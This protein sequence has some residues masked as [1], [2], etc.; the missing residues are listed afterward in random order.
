MTD[1][2]PPD[3]P[4]TGMYRNSEIRGFKN[5]TRALVGFYCSFILILATFIEC[6]F[7]ILPGSLSTSI[8][9]V[10]LVLAAVA[11]ALVAKT[12]RDSDM[13]LRELEAA[14]RDKP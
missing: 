4:R 14:K 11:L 8:A 10:V 7:L 1:T 12:K 3:S 9:V 6:V 2:H 5:Y 13:I